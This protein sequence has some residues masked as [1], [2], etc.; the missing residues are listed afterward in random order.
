[1]DTSL[2]NINF[3]NIFLHDYNVI[4]YHLNTSYSKENYMKTELKSAV[5]EQAWDIGK[6]RGKEVLL[7]IHGNMTSS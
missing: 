7:L 1:M 4:Q 5:D 6:R 3:Y 2:L